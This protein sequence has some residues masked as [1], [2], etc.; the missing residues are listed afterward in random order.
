[1]D[2]NGLKT[3][4]DQLLLQIKQKC[5]E[6]RAIWQIADEHIL[7]RELVFCLLTP[8][9]NAHRAWDA[10]CMMERDHFLRSPSREKLLPIV[11]MVRFH[12]NKTSYILEA[13]KKHYGRLQQPLSSFANDE[14]RRSW[15]VQSVKGLGMKEASHYL[16][17]IGFME[18]LAILDR[19]ILRRLCELQVITEV[20]SSLSYKRYLQIEEAMRRFAEAHTI[21]MA[22]LD[23][24]FWFDANRE[25]FK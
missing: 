17:N 21:P 1:M 6:F 4:H 11:H 22:H 7:F 2:V 12:N 16:R 25:L 20:P 3:L 23:M 19:H 15:L 14:Q 10:V 18:E 5:D 24:V 9:S 8:Q 13:H